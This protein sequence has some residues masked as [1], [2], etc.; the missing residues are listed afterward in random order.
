[1]VCRGRER[2]GDL[3][4]DQRFSSVRPAPKASRAVSRQVV[5]TIRPPGRAQRDDGAGI[6]DIRRHTARSDVR[7]ALSPKS[8]SGSRLLAAALSQTLARSRVRV[9]RTL[10]GRNKNAHDCLMKR[11]QI[12]RSALVGLVAE[13]LV[14]RRW[15]S[16]RRG[17]LQL[18]VT[19][20]VIRD[21][22]DGR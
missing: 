16:N 22:M 12:R 21:V 4:M 17:S 19:C 11:S 6:A 3:V 14:T 2:R 18:V 15:G 9:H 1:M 8:L 5:A 7:C 13:A 20:D 10:T